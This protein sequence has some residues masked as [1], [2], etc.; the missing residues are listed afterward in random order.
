MRAAVVAGAPFAATDLELAA[1]HAADLLIAA[2]SGAR[3]LLRLGLSPQLVVGDLDSIDAA[4]LERL[5]GQGVTVEVHPVRKDR[6]DTHLALLAALERGA[7]DIALLGAL[8][9]TRPD[10]GMAN[11]LLLRNYAFAA[12]RLRLIEGRAETHVVREALE[13]RGAPG[14]YVTLLALTEEVRGVTTEGLE[15]EVRDF[16]LHQGESLGVS[17]QL[18]STYARVTIGKGVLLVAHLHG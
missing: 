3:S 16:T 14:D 18:V 8:G 9:G 5:R 1:L 4:T 7:D 2:D 17:N 12:V 10:H 13:L 6:T 15:W 11:I